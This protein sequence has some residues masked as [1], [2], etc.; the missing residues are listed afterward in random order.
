MLRE[1]QD[2]PPCAYLYEGLPC[3]AEKSEGAPIAPV[4]AALRDA[5]PSEEG[6]AIR[7]PSR[8]YDPSLSRGFRH[9]ALELRYS[10][11]RIGAPP[12]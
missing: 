11:H 5:V 3:W 12:R 9:Q 10:L 1:L 7:F 8:V 6:A 2:P 4:C